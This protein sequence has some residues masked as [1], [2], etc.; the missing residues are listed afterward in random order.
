MTYDEFRDM[1]RSMRRLQKD[2]FRSRNQTILNQCRDMERRVDRELDP[3][4]DQPQ[5][6][7]VGGEG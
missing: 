5:M 1:V 3:T 7:D 6:F 2:Y 4:K